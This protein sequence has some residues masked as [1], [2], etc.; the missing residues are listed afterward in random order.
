MIY[1]F[2]PDS[3]SRWL[4]SISPLENKCW[5]IFFNLTLVF[6]FF[7]KSKCRNAQLQSL[8]TRQKSIGPHRPLRARSHWNAMGNTCSVPVPHTALMICSGCQCKFDT[9]NAMDLPVLDRTI[10]KVPRDPVRVSKS[11]ACNYFCCGAISA[12]SK[13]MWLKTH[14]T[15]LH[16]NGPAFLKD[17]HADPSVNNP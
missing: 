8:K 15:E 1:T 7:F 12:H 9:P 17:S 4:M 2:L 13:W 10:Q 14:C 11:S 5:L 3:T 16:V 6:F